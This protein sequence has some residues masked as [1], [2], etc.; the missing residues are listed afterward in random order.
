MNRARKP[1]IG[2]NPLWVGFFGVVTTKNAGRATG[3]NRLEAHRQ[4]L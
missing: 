2:S 3:T 1:Q 4:I